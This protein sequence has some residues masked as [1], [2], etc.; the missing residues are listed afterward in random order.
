MSREASNYLACAANATTGLGGNKKVGD[1]IERLIITVATAA[2]AQT[3]IQ[4]G[5]NTAITILPNSPGGGVGVY[6]VELNVKS[7]AGGWSVITGAGATVV[8]V[9]KFTH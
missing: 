1:F 3:Q 7:R 5:A 2:S 4:D 6:V 9:G 8:A